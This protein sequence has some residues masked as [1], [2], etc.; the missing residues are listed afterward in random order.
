[1]KT[2]CLD[3]FY[4]DLDKEISKERCIKIKK[5]ID[6][7]DLDTETLTQLIEKEVNHD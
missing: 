2:E 3:N 1:M 4:N 6:E 7:E 5:L